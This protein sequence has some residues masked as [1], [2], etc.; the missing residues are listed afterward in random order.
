[1]NFDISD[2][3]VSIQISY[4]CEIKVWCAEIQMLLHIDLCRN[5]LKTQYRL[6]FRFFKCQS[7][8][9]NFYVNTF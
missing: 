4:T 7:E 2:L 3:I 1:M 9:R 8:I 5:F 6:I